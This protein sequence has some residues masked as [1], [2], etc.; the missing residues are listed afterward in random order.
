MNEIQLN[1]MDAHPLRY[2]FDK[3]VNINPMYDSDSSIG[4]LSLIHI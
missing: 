4:D 3:W 2:Y 1:I